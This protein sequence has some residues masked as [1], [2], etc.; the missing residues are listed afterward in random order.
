[1]EMN[2]ITYKIFK[3]SDLFEIKRGKRIVKNIDYFTEK[4]GENTFPVITA[5]T[6]DNGIDGYYDKF[7][8]N[9]NVIVCAG[10]ANGL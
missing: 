2:N 1:M 3:I 8:C 6:S 4:I 9:G 5:K 7:N 10:E